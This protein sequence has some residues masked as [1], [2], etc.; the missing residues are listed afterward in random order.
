MNIA[1]YKFPAMTIFSARNTYYTTTLIIKL[2]FTTY[3]IFRINQYVS[4]TTQAYICGLI[5]KSKSRKSRESSAV[6]EIA[7]I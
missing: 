3:T 7:K 5:I 6:E 2:V 1:I 4:E